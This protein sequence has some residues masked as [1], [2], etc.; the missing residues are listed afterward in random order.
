MGNQLPLE[1]TE[2]RKVGR[3][4]G[5]GEVEKKAGKEWKWIRPGPTGGEETMHSLKLTFSPLRNDGFQ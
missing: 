1:M 4:K 3:E 5:H 2:K